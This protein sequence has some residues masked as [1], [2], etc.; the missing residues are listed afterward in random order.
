[1]SHVVHVIMSCLLAFEVMRRRLFWLV[2]EWLNWMMRMM[3]V[4]L[5]LIY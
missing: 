3:I 5:N 2:V 1:M 4:E